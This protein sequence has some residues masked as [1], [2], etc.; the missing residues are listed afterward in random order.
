MV[1][2]K[3]WLDKRGQK[4]IFIVCLSFLFGVMGGAIAANLMGADAKTELSGVVRNA[5]EIQQTGSFT[6]TFWKYLK[7]DIIIWLGGWLQLGLFLSGMAF[8]L[9]SI[10]LGFASAMMMV[11][12]G[13]KGVWSAMLTL[14]PQNIVL[15]PAYIFIMCTAI[16]YLLTWNEGKGKRGL[17]RERRR[18]QT[19]YC[20][21]FAAS[22]ILIA[23]GAGIEVV[24]YP[25]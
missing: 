3:T 9:R 22:V 15:I 8:L 14:L 24:L 12:Y 20:L 7:Y 17:K 2:R 4:I 11:T 10:S 6:V 25:L 21:L 1:K 5:I 23:I 19:E 18:K 16:Y 13:F